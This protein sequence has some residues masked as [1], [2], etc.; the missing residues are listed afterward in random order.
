MAVIIARS[1]LLNRPPGNPFEINGSSRAHSASLRSLGYQCPFADITDGARRHRYSASTRRRKQSSAAQHSFGSGPSLTA[2]VVR[3]FGRPAG[4]CIAA[5]A[6]R[7]GFGEC[8]D[9][10]SAHRRDR[11]VDMPLG[12]DWRRLWVGNPREWQIARAARRKRVLR[13]EGR[14]IRRSESR[15]RR[16]R[17]WRGGGSRAIRALHNHPS[18]VPA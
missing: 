2:S 14:L 1:V 6:S 15:R 9:Q 4:R 5:R 8:D 7:K 13:G 18:R 12:S 11:V 16:Y 10:P 17:V 3:N